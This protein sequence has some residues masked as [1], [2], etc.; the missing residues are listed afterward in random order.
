MRG[1]DTAF[2]ILT[3]LQFGSMKGRRSLSGIEGLLPHLQKGET[4]YGLHPASCSMGKE[5]FPADK[6][7][8][9]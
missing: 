5:V 4:C 7:V 1:W 3:R 2:G 8:G 9:V 6:A